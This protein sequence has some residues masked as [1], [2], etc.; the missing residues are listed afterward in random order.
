MPGTR[1]APKAHFG[2]SSMPGCIGT[3]RTAAGVTSVVGVDLGTRHLGQYSV[4][5]TWESN[6]RLRVVFDCE[7]ERQCDTRIVSPAVAKTE[8]RGL[9]FRYVNSERVQRVLS[10]ADSPASR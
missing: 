5:L 1:R 7:D 6:T 9:T 4:E 3:S 2:E 8:A 10:S